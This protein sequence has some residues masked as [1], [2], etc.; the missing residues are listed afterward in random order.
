MPDSKREIIQAMDGSYIDKKIYDGIFTEIQ[1]YAELPLMLELATYEVAQSEDDSFK[2]H[3]VT[4]HISG[5]IEILRGIKKALIPL[6]K[7]V[8]RMKIDLS[9][10]MDSMDAIRYRKFKEF[11]DGFP[12]L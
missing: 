5:M 3:A 8:E 4:Y 7:E 9:M 12:Y 1:T 11:L 6:E 10:E 2:E